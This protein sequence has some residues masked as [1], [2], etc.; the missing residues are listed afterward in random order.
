MLLRTLV[1]SC[2]WLDLAMSEMKGKM[3]VPLVL[4]QHESWEVKECNKEHK[5]LRGYLNYVCCHV[6]C[7][8]LPNYAQM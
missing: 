5:D 4:Y 2:I 3:E 6:F 1:D 8:S 7:E